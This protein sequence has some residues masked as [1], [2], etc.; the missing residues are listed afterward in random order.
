MSGFMPG[1]RL[2]ATLENHSAVRI[3]AGYDIEGGFL[4]GTFL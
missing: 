3:S 1:R 4:L 2:A